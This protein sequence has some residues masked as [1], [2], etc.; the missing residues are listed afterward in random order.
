MSLIERVAPQCKSHC[1]RQRD[2]AD[3]LFRIVEKEMYLICDPDFVR[4]SRQ[5]G[6]ARRARSAPHGLSVCRHAEVLH[7]LALGDG[8]A[9]GARQGRAEASHR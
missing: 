9:T 1:G 7:L 2:F 8:V 3:W 6:Q 5:T 4:L